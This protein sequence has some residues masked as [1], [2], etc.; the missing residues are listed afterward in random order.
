MGWLGKKDLSVMHEM[1]EGRSKQ[2]NSY[3][4]MAVFTQKG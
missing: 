1:V 2:L 4:S 3:V